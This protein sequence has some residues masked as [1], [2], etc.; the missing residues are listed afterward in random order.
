VTVRALTARGLPQP[1]GPFSPATVAEGARI[2]SLSGQIAQDKEGRLVGGE[3]AEAQARQCLRN[4]GALLE[5]AGARREDVVRVTVFLTD[6]ADR[7]A[8]ARAREEFFGE[9]RPAATLVEVS[10]L[11]APEYRVEIEATAVY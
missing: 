4:L 2:L 9:H 7:A 10:A 8:V 5:A 1:G 11:V 3:S 6:V